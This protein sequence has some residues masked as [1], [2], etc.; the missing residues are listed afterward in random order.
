MGTGQD[1]SPYRRHTFSEEKVG[2]KTFHIWLV[3]DTTGFLY[4]YPLGN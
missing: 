1:N 2:K 3:G 4:I